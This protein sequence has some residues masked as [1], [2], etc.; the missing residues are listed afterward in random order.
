VEGFR[1]VL[2]ERPD[3]QAARTSAATVLIATGRAKDAVTLLRQAPADQANSPDL[4]A[5]LGVALREAG[6]LQSAVAML[7]RARAGGTQNPEL[8]NDLGVVYARL[9]RTREARQLFEELLGRD[10]DAAATW[11]NLGVLELSSGRA[12]EAAVAFRHAVD[13]DDTRGDAW[14]GL[15]AALVGHDR[16]GAIDAWRRAE[17]LLPRDYDLLFN[18]GMVLADSPSPRESLPYLERFVREAPRD[19]YA[20]DIARVE[21]VIRRVSR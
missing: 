9:G 2:A 1:A 16:P 3:F 12:R 15:G 17:R 11:N 10:P 21:A 20:S 5:K 8:A 7:E 18:L 19:Q 14:Q 4:L 6:D 13:A